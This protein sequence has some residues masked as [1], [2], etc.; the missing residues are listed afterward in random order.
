M[1]IYP[2]VALALVAYVCLTVTLCL[3]IQTNIGYIYECLSKPFHC[4]IK[5]IINQTIYN[6]TFTSIHKMILLLK[7]NIPACHSSRQS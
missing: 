2:N 4:L 3:S 6:M 1:L 7:A 5:V